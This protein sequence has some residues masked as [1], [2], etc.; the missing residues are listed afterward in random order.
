MR[1]FKN[2]TFNFIL[3]HGLENQ[4]ENIERRVL[5]QIFQVRN[6]ETNKGNKAIIDEIVEGKP[7]PLL[8]A[9]DEL[10][11]VILFSD[12][13]PTRKLFQVDVKVQRSSVGIAAYTVMELHDVVDMEG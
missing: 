4:S 1:I 10:R 11:D 13:N 7:V 3:C 2:C 9:S 6:A 8:F 12:T 5:M